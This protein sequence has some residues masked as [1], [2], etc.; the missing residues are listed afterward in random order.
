MARSLML[1]SKFG[2]LALVLSLAAFPAFCQ[3][4]APQAP[5]VLDTSSELEQVAPG[6]MAVER[7]KV[8]DMIL[9]A[10]EQKIG[11]TAYLGAFKSLEDQVKAGAQEKQIKSRLESI[12]ISLGEQLK[13]SKELKSQKPAPPVAA[14]SPTSG[15]GSSKAGLDLSGSNTDK[16]INKLRDKWFGGEIPDSIKKKIPPGIDPSKMDNDTIKDLLKKYG[17]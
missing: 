10:K 6:P 14:S 17:Q 9:A 4:Q 12:S 8:L 1:Q 2:L 7:Q 16:M 11:I 3:E 13:R 15:E 5:V